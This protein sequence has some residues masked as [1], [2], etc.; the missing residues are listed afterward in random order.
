MVGKAIENA[1]IKGTSVEMLEKCFRA[2]E[3]EIIEDDEVLSENVYNADETGFSDTKMM[4]GDVNNKRPPQN[5]QFRGD[6]RCMDL[7]ANDD[8]KTA[9]MSKVERGVCLAGRAASLISRKMICLICRDS[10]GL[11][12][13]PPFPV[14][15]F[16]LP[17]SG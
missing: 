12:T 2:F 9:L 10:G 1:R 3:M 4:R 17:F 5:F 16:I 6:Q 14:S 7:R 15:H 8:E 13:P 11:I